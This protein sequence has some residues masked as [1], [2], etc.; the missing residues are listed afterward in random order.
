M[1]MVASHVV[2]LECRAVLCHLKRDEWRIGAR[3]EV[4]SEALGTAGPNDKLDEI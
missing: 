2:S 4:C 1:V 3:D